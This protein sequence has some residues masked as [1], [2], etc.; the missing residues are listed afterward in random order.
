MVP[1]IP[2]VAP[3]S[4]A[5]PLPDKP[6]L[7]VLPFTNMGADPEQDH[8]A[9]GITEDIIT[10]VSRIS[11]FFV[12]ARNSTFTYRGTTDVRQVGRELGVRYIVEGTVRR[13]G[14]RVRVTVH[15]LEASTGTHIWSDR[16]DRPLADL[17]EVQ[18]DITRS[19]VASTQTQVVLNEGLLAERREHPDFHTWD[20]AKR[21]WREIYQ[22]TR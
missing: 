2:Q 5:L 3:Q 6:S 20:M 9:E 19:I 7:A 12:I 11:A 10:E 18:D 1:P 13:A 17:F 15:L 22:L 14:A 8:F 21:G 4:K 16:Y